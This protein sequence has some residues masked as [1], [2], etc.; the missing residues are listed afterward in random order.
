MAHDPKQILSILDRCC[1]RYTFPML[2][3]GYVYL[4]ATRL[5]LYR[6]E[7][8]WALVVEVFGFSPRAGSPDTSIYTFASQLC[9]RNEEFINREARDLHI[10]NNPHNEMRFV[11]PVVNGVSRDAAN[12]EFLSD[13]AEE[14]VVR[15]RSMS[16]PTPTEYAGHGIELEHRPRVQVFELCRYL[17][18]VVREEVLAT[19]QERRVNVLPDM[20]QV[21][22]LEEWHHPNV[23]DDEERPSNSET[24]QQLAQVLVSGR[25]EIYRPTRAPNTHWINWP[26]G[27]RL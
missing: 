18:D 3:N 17:A 8:D 16:L 12:E 14:L 1:D 19:P 15:G 24:F 27:G 26:Q 22:Q 13:D 6:S 11:F 20:K 25:A 5:S 7:S 4:A 21:L 10:L 23:V 2:D 9:S